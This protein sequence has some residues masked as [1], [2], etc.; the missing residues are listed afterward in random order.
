LIIALFYT[1]DLNAYALGGA[2]LVAGLMA[3]LNIAGVRRLWPYL[4]L[5]GVLW[6]AV[7][8]SGV[9]A[10]I[11]GVIAALTIPLGRGEPYSPLR[12]LEH[13]IHPW[14]MFGVVPLFGFVSAGVHISGIGEILQPLPLAIALGLFL[15]KQAG[16]FGA[17]WVAV[18]S[19]FAQ[20][21]AGASWQQI[22]GAAML[23][24]I[25]FTMS[26][27]IGALAFPGRPEEIEAAKLG[28]LAGS[29]L[30]AVGGWLVLRT[31]PAADPIEED[32]G[33]AAEI[34]G[35]DWEE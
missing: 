26:L 21:P 13:E 8:A 31:A 33:E 15:G 17:T 2:L 25:G 23:C 18:K 11:A 19:G 35:E 34:F 16:V 20:R 32:A 27:F 7:L 3:F 24:G 28:T 9:H 5:A 1:S 12:K 22:Y 30:A 14:V 6:F 10:T 4:M 29:F